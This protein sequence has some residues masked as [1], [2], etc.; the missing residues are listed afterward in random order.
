MPNIDDECYDA[1]KL[2]IDKNKYQE[3]PTYIMKFHD[4]QSREGIKHLMRNGGIAVVA[5][6]AMIAGLAEGCTIVHG[7]DSQHPSLQTTTT[8]PRPSC[9]MEVPITGN[10]T[11]TQK[12]DHPFTIIVVDKIQP[13]N[14][15][16]YAFVFNG[17]TI[18]TY[19]NDLVGRAIPPEKYGTF[20]LSISNRDIFYI[21]VS[22]VALGEKQIQNYSRNGI[23]SL[24]DGAQKGVTYRWPKI[25][26][27]NTVNDCV[28]AKDGSVL[29]GDN[30]SVIFQTYGK[31]G[32]NI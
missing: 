7:A 8:Q 9:I 20:R 16:Q 32:V 6:A 28:P 21:G 12:Q 5:S 15:I 13:E 29:L 1:H 23:N 18:F 3:T 2:T 19:D 10:I 14:A 22:D 11:I 17:T 24:I 25:G 31:V 4:M 26:T 30:I 27:P